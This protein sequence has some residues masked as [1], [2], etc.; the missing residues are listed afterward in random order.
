MKKQND[1]IK[2]LLK[3]IL[4]LSL[5]IIFLLSCVTVLVFIFTAAWLRTYKSFTDREK[6]AEIELTPIESDTRGLDRFEVKYIQ[7]EGTTG[8]EKLFFPDSE[9]S[10][11]VEFEKEYTMY[12]DTVLIEAHTVKLPDALTL[13]NYKALFKIT[14]I[15][16]DYIDNREKTKQLSGDERSIYD[17]NGGVD[18]TWEFIKRNESKL[19][20]FIDTAEISSK[21][22]A[23]SDSPEKYS[24]FI[25]EEGIVIDQ[26]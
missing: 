20:I 7:F 4:T 13:L 8:F 24:I 11:N 14:G 12:G 3:T 18:S 22:K 10:T 6:I 16:G 9:Y 21:G 15:E 23:V 5:V 17:L 26:E 2:N 1:L 25:T 19:R